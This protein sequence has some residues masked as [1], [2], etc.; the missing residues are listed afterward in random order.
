[1]CKRTMY[2]H[3][4][5]PMFLWERRA[6]ANSGA[7]A[8]FPRPHKNGLGT[9]LTM[10]IHIHDCLCPNSLCYLE[11]SYTYMMTSIHLGKTWELCYIQTYMY[12]ACIHF[13]K[14]FLLL[15]EVVY[16]CFTTTLSTTMFTGITLVCLLKS[17]CI[18]S[19]ILIG[20]RVSKLHA[21]LRPYCNVWPEA[22]YCCLTLLP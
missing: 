17:V 16:C 12:R 11:H 6:C 15:P 20:C 10:Y 8:V 14:F 18:S 7:Q 22:V 3:A 5:I 19:Y 9:R 2:K 21:R 4:R 13:T 1:M